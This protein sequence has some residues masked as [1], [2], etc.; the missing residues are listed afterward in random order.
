MGCEMKFKWEDHRKKAILYLPEEI[1]QQAY[2]L[3]WLGD[4]SMP[5][6]FY[7]RTVMQTE[8]MT[9]EQWISFFNIKIL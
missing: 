6:K 5:S 9:F 7:A 1:A 4:I 2:Q 3:G 8:Q